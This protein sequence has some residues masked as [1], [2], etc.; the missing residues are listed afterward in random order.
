[1]ISTTDS[2]QSVRYKYDTF[3]VSYTP[4]WLSQSECDELT[5]LLD[6]RTWS[7][8]RRSSLLYGNA[9]ASYTVS[10]RGHSHT[11]AA[12][13]WTDIPILQT[14]LHRLQH[15]TGRTFQVCAVQYY[16]DGTV[17]IGT[18]RDKEIPIDGHIYGISL[19]AARVIRFNRGTV[20]HDCTLAH[21]SLYHISGVTNKYWTHEITTD[22]DI[23][24]PRYS[25]TFRDCGSAQ[26]KSSI[27]QIQ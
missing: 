15:S 23:T 17:G 13:D 27:S 7:T 1:M 4:D 20:T 25:C 24:A 6:E 12:L 14:I 19:G 16:H 5:R 26:V 10:Y 9:D 8:S 18:H 22:P 21:G 3:D 11:R 2:T